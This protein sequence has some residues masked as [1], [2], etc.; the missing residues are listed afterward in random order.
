MAAAGGRSWVMA[1]AAAAG[2]H[3]LLALLPIMDARDEASAA[4]PVVHLRLASPRQPVAPPTARD[5]PAPTSHEQ[6][7]KQR[8]AKGIPLRSVR[9][10]LC[11]SAPAASTPVSTEVAV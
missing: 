8:G 7:R 5:E 3:A 10:S 4:P 11:F 9:G 2:A 6:R 1:I